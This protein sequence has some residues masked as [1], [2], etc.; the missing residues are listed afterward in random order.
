MK[1]DYI[2]ENNEISI[3][4]ISSDLNRKLF[5]E[6]NMKIQFPKKNSNLRKLVINENFKLLKTFWRR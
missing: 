6:P 5:V 2:P 3:V 1:I 4:N